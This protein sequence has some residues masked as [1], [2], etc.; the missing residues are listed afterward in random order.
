MALLPGQSFR[1]ASRFAGKL[2][3]AKFGFHCDTPGYPLL[4]H[5]NIHPMHWSIYLVIVLSSTFT[6]WFVVWVGV[7]MLF[8]PQLSE[9]FPGFGLQGILLKNRQEFASQMGRLAAAEFSFDELAQ[10]A[11]GPENFQKLQPAI[12]A[13]VDHFLNHKL[14]EVF[15]MLGMLI[16]EKTTSQLKTAFLTELETLFPDV[17][18]G[19]IANLQ[20]DM[21]IEKM[22]TEKIASLPSE[23][24][25]GLLQG[26]L[27]KELARVQ[28]AGAVLG[29]FVGI[30]EIVV[31]HLVK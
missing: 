28:V 20:Q 14:K 16:G 1:H 22:V 31:F 24:F 30:L 17:M 3:P 7:K 25:E 6:G 21:D 27:Q 13:H 11:T 4:L 8:S 18:K 29:F 9:Q 23:K 19:H 10:K 2:K 5:A 26:I 15:P 12:E